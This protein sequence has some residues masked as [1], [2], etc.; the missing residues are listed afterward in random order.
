MYRC[1]IGIPGSGTCSNCIKSKNQ[2]IF[3]PVSAT[4]SSNKAIISR[5]QK[6]S[7]SITTPPTY[8]SASSSETVPTTTSNDTTE[9]SISSP[10]LLSPTTAK[11]SQYLSKNMHEIQNSIF[12]INSRG[13]CGYE[14]HSSSLV[15][16]HILLQSSMI[17]PPTYTPQMEKDLLQIYFDNVHPFY[18]VLD[19]FYIHQFSRTLP[20]ALKFAI[21]A[22]AVHFTLYED[23]QT[24][25]TAFY[26]HATLHLDHTPNLLNIQT[27]LLLYKFQEIITPVGL[28]PSVVAVNFLKEIQTMLIHQQKKENDAVTEEYLCRT[29]WITF[30]VV[31]FCSPSDD[32]WQP[33]MNSCVQPSRFPAL[34]EHE[35][36]DKSE[37]NIVCNLF[38]LVQFAVLFSQTV[39]LISQQNTLFTGHGGYPELESLAASFHVWK[40]SLP[41][42]I[43][44]SLDT[45]PPNM[46]SAQNLTLNGPDGS[47]S[48]SFI[49]YL[50]LLCDTL[51]L[52]FDLH[53]NYDNISTKANLVSCRAH[54]FTVG[55]MLDSGSLRRATIQGNR[56]VCYSLALATQSYSFYLD[57]KQNS[58][59]S[60]DD[61][62]KFYS[63]C[64]LVFQIMGDIPLSSQL[65][66]TIQSLRNQFEAKEQL[67]SL[68]AQQ[69]PML[70]HHGNTS[71]M[72]TTLPVHS[73]LEDSSSST[74][75]VQYAYGPDQQQQ[76]Y[77][78][79]PPP[80][81]DRQ[82]Q[83]LNDH[84][85]QQHRYE[86]HPTM[87]PDFDQEVTTP[88]LETVPM[89]VD[90]YF[91]HIPE[92]HRRP[93]STI[94]INR[95]DISCVAVVAPQHPQSSPFVP[96]NIDISKSCKHHV[97]L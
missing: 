71:Y 26:H 77:A 18:P 60:S 67:T 73:I 43:K 93:P 33:L 59:A 55:D 41:N 86:Y 4:S 40:S 89:M 95:P 16:N 14:N 88:D 64:S 56:L 52:L 5:Q 32:R 54:S 10:I 70:H 62:K 1:D 85:Q 30:V 11:K 57:Q 36:Y 28:S 8:S 79:E 92:R 37:L 45:D 29:G 50:G 22:V 19:R 42:H 48:S 9:T 44:Q 81:E 80:H 63:I 74:N 69:Q 66:I 21:M 72:D 91:D 51:D 24:M 20:K 75:D 87:T 31:S 84:S 82:W 38:H 35:Q 27:L 6:K 39:S 46:Y 53:H 23:A 3:S 49:S 96:M 7:F 65:H 2:C 61:I 47:K 15:Y 83:Y 78:R 34:T 97:L 76:S 17:D 58:T 13:F 90:S 68:E 12:S 25:A 94:Y